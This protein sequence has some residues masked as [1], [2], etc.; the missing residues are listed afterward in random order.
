MLSE[1]PTGA[2][3]KRWPTENELEMPDSPWL[4]VDEE[5]LRLRRVAVLEWVHCVV[6]NPA[7]GKAL[8]TC[9]SLILWDSRLV[10]GPLAHLKS[11]LAPFLVSD[12]GVGDTTAKLGEF[13]SLVLIVPQSTRGQV[14]ALNGQRQGVH[15]YFNGQPRQG[16]AHSGLTCSGQPR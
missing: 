12:L 13:N 10:R 7:N 11:F 16:N 1:W 14:T 9:P 6:P 5:I 8:K 3:V 4:S 2:F 15:S